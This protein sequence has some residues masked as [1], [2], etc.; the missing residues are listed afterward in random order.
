MNTM[1]K[2]DYFNLCDELAKNQSQFIEG[3]YAYRSI[4]TPDTSTRKTPITIDHYD[5]FVNLTE[6]FIN[7]GLNSMDANML[8]EVI[9]FEK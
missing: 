2:E 4:T 7:D 6:D 1:K 8:A 9:V 3:S 5:Q